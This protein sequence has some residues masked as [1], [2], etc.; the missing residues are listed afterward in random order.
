MMDF[1]QY[2]LLLDL[3]ETQN[4]TNTAK[5]LGYT[6]PGASHIL[7]KI[8]NELGFSVIFREKYGVTLTPAAELLLPQ[9]RKIM[10]EQEQLYQTISA[11]NGLE[12]G[13]VT[14]GTYSSVA[15]HL[16]PEILRQFKEVHPSLEIDIREGGADNILD[17]MDKNIIDFA[18][19]SRP[20]AK[21]LEFLSYGKDPLL[22]I[23][24]GDFYLENQ[25][26]FRIE[27]F[28]GMPFI[29]SA[30]GND[31]D[32]HNALECSGVLPDYS[33]SVLD[34]HTI[35][36]MVEHNLGVSMVT[37][38]IATDSHYNVKLLPIAPA[39]CRDM[40][41]AMAD[42]D[43]L[44]KAARTFV[45]FAIQRLPSLWKKIVSEQGEK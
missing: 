1:Q 33:Y 27:D 17:W 37:Q 11:I 42:Y 24:P 23:L 14:I 8:E 45:D 25:E 43:K 21:E 5:R 3:A 35:M 20:Y 32:I 41:I 34:D 10:V 38:L 19:I 22:A 30:D 18:F 4:I 29:L 16:L 2:E 12:Y 44:S 9:I 13:K 39:Y 6:Q 26:Y 15:V 40:G 36:S 28:E 31:F 7:K